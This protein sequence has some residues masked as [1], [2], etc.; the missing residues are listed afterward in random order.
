MKAESVRKDKRSAIRVRK[1]SR[2]H[3]TVQ[4]LEL[5]PYVFRLLTL[6]KSCVENEIVIRRMPR[7][8]QRV[9][10][11]GDEAN[12]P[13]SKGP[14]LHGVAQRQRWIAAFQQC[15]PSA[16]VLFDHIKRFRLIVIDMAHHPAILVDAG[17]Q[18]SARH[19]GFL[20]CRPF[21]L[22]ANELHVACSGTGR[23]HFDTPMPNCSTV[24]PSTAFPP[25]GSAAG[26]V[27]ENSTVLSLRMCAT[28]PSCS[29]HQS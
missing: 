13:A 6:L 23:T 26:M 12:H 5:V 7:D 29:S 16:D 9:H 28:A 15:S 18:S 17:R 22:M 10:R 19:G 4:A 11:Q 21:T 25:L 24:A 2:E 20:P 8:A 14:H 27:R 1:K 3:G